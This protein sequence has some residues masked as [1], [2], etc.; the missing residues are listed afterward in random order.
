MSEHVTSLLPL[1]SGPTLRFLPV[2]DFFLDD[3]ACS[4]SSK[5]FWI[6]S[7]LTTNFPFKIRRFP[8]TLSF[9]FAWTPLISSN[10]LPRIWFS[11]CNR[12]AI[13]LRWRMWVLDWQSSVEV[14]SDVR[15]ARLLDRSVA[16]GG[17]ELLSK[18]G[19]FVV[20]NWWTAEVLE[21]SRGSGSR[22]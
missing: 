9:L 11:A 16:G 12:S 20:S 21:T 18:K 13:P 7:V 2:V 5:A 3:V 22:T 1:I 10:S 4:A 19:V 8:D 6:S 15:K 14:S 17:G